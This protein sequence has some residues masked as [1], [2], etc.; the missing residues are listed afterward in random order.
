MPVNKL[1]LFALFCGV[2]VFSK[3][4]SAQCPVTVDAGPD[5]FVC[6]PGESVQLEGNISGNYLGFRWSPVTGLDDPVLLNPTATVNSTA[7]YTLTAAAFDPSAPNLVNN[8]GFEAGNTGFTSGYIYNPAPIIPGTYV[9][10]TSPD[11]VLSNFPPCDDHTYGNGTGNM[12]L[13]NGTGG[14][15]SQVWCQT[16]P[17]MANS[18]YS[19]GAWVA[20][21]P[22]APPVLQFNVNGSFIGNEFSAS[23]GGCFWEE[24]TATWFSGAS[25]SAQ[26]CIHDISGSGNGL[27][28]DDFALDDIFMAKACT[29]TDQVTVSVAQVQAVLPLSIILPCSAQQNGIQLDGSGSSS[30]PGYSYAWDGPGILIGGDTPIA[31]VNEPG[32]YTLTVSFDT[33]NGICTKTASITVLPDPA[34]VTASAT[35]LEELNCTTATA[36]LDGSGSSVGPFISYSWEPTTAIVSGNGTLNPTVNQPGFYTLTV[37]NTISG[38]TETATVYVSQNLAP[39]MAAA[40][41]PAP[42]TCASDTVTLS[43]AGS[44]TGFQFSYQWSG[45]GIVS[46]ATTLNNCLVDAPGLY[47]LTV[48]N[49]ISTC[50]ATATA[51]V[52]QNTVPPIAMA[53]ADAPGALDCSTDSLTLNSAGSSNGAGF[54]YLWSTPNGHF[55][56]PVDGPSAV[57][58]SLGLYILTVT[59]TQNGCTAVDSVAVQATAGQPVIALAQPLPVFHCATDSVLLD[60][61]ASVG[62]PALTVQWTTPNGSILSG[63]TTLTPWLGGPGFYIVQLSNPA[64]GCSATDTFLIALDTLAPQ[65]N[66]AIPGQLDCQ[67]NTLQLDASGSSD[68]S[69]IVL[70]WSFTPAPGVSGSG[71]VSGQNSL[72]PLID[73]PGIYTLTLTDTL[74]FCTAS[75]TVIVQQDT[76]P[77]LADAGPDRT[78]TCI[79][80]ADTLDGGNSSQGPGLVYLWNTGDTTLL[81]PVSTPGLYF[82]QVTNTANHCVGADSVMVQLLND[83]PD[84]AIDTPGLLTCVQ[85]Q[86]QLQAIASGGPEFSYQWIFTGAGAGILSGDTTLTPVAG[87]PG[88]YVLTVTNTLTGCSAS[89]SQTLQ[90][91]A[92]LPLADAG[93]AQT[94]FCGTPSV[95]LDGSMSDAGQDITYLWTTTDGNILAGANTQMPEVNAPGT[96]QLLVL[97]TLTGCSATAEVLVQLDANAPAAAVI[98][99][100]NLSCVQTEVLL[101]GSG[102]SAG[103]NFSYQWTGPGLVSGTGGLTPLVNAP[104]TYSLQVTDVTNGCT[105]TAT[106][107][108]SADTTQPVAA[109]FAAQNLSCVQTEVPLDGN[110]SSAGANFSY[111]WTGPGLVSG[112]GG[113]TPLVNAPGTY[114]LQVTDVTNGCTATATVSVS[115]DTTQPVAAIF[116]AQNLSCVQTEVPLDGNGSSAGAN[117]SYQWTGPGLVSGTGGLT[118]L[119]N[120]P[121]SYSLQVTDATNGCTATATVLVSADTTQPVA[122]IFAAQNLSCVQTEV[123]LDGNGSSAGANFS[124]QWTGPGLVSGTGGLTPLVNTPGSYSLQVTDA[125]NGCTATATVDVSADTTQPVAA[126][127]AAQN[128]SCVQTE[129]PLDGNG[130]SAG[131]NF[132]YQWTGPGLVSGTGG[133][134]PL[135]NTPGSYSLQVTD[136]TNGCTATATV[137]VSADTTQP[138]AAIFAAQNL[139]C[140]QTEV[141]LNGNGSSAGI[142]F[143]YQW[144]GPGLVIG[145]GDLTPLANTP[146]TY[147]LQVTD[148]TN[149]CTATATAV[150]LANTTPPAAQAGPDAGLSCNV[151]VLTLQGSSATPG[152]FFQWSTVN[153]SI[154][155]GPNTANPEVDA[156]GQYVLVVTDPQNGCTASD[157]VTIVAISTEF[158]SVAAVVPTCLDTLGSILFTG[159]PFGQGPYLYSIDNGVSFGQDSLFAALPPGTYQT[160]V[161]DAGGCEQQTTV[162]LPVIT[163]ITVDLP[164]NITL[165]A[166]ATLS[167]DP[168][169]NIPA[170]ALASVVWT[171]G[172]GLSCTDCLNP[173]ASPLANTSYQVVVVSQSGCTASAVIQITVNTTAEVYVPNVFSP[174]GDGFNDVFQVQTNRSME[175]FELRIFDRWGGLLFESADPGIGWDGTARGKAMNPGVYAYFIRFDTENAAGEVERML[176]EGGVLLLR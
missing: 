48:T 133:L 58:D 20:S 75:D 77:P 59:N 42:L 150:V 2:L 25:T 128:L 144:T 16:I 115:V 119:V 93:P 172:A 44:S 127:F 140:V 175:N 54:T 5:K 110:G 167:L 147:S 29:A 82:L 46:G 26:V 32:L 65:I 45:P 61:S 27:F 122:A 109:I 123:P 163:P 10:T 70:L 12:M 132:S 155:S 43:G 14:S 104:G 143:S 108:V 53:N 40:A 96:Y 92:D 24:F 129:V 152:V 13:V 73:A 171:P 38:C 99:A 173:V 94:L 80:L 81:V 113:L 4:T 9:L 67:T 97:D 112:T 33:G 138:V 35:A 3:N 111:Q 139:S 168:V 37:T 6:S 69:S 49:G 91:S 28:G 30:G 74:N 124:Y 156:P 148:V 7:T 17:V 101:D 142:N 95:L 8:P 21:S 71:F 158:P 19:L 87:S 126:I 136:A 57:I 1:T 107:S 125:T 55:T 130:S 47:T 62:G 146:G 135:V 154:L 157:S 174:N 22:I 141:P 88:E 116:A 86:L 41:A 15:N 39:A 79:V 120:A 51:V 34:T 52:T 83:L 151:P 118:P 102:S 60:A 11:L 64:S 68:S 166:G 153:G 137:L 169:L 63:D 145:M 114:S 170:S 56:G 164:G 84:V 100:Q 50:T 103:V 89:A 160:V 66:L 134:T 36:M 72:T 98:A 76:L 161:Q 121:G 149:G 31:T 23:G 18:W 131:A 105:A 176:L 117:F 85:P 162:E 78:L 159:G 106:V 90:Q 165:P